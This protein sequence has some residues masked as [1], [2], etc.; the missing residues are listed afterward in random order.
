MIVTLTPN[1]SIDRTVT[2]SGFAVG[3]VNRATSVRQ[4]PGGKGVNV[5]RAVSAH[6]APSLAVMPLGGA[7]GQMMRQ[8]LAQADVPVDALTI[9][10]T[11]RI[12]LTLA[13]AAGVTTKVNEPG[14]A[15]RAA[16]VDDLLARCA[17]QVKEGTWVLGA[18]SLPPR[19]TDDFYVRLVE[20]VQ[21]AGGQVAVDSSGPAFLRALAA[22]PDLVKP[23][24]HELGEALGRPLATLGAIIDGA[25]ELVAGGISTV[26]VSLGGSGALAVTE[27]EVLHAKA[28]KV[29][30]VSTVGAGDALLAGYLLAL[31]RGADVRTALE[32]GIR[33]GTAA[34]T[35]PGSVMPGPHDIEKVS[36]TFSDELDLDVAVEE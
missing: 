16:E 2:L 13:D 21:A 28:A 4:D 5:S 8:L 11:T 17:R 22:G 33:F 32:N 29:R 9:E 36:V 6:G 34:V 20:T 14:P 26:V 1:P 19:S 15:L 23:N 35:L 3:S 10:D 30:P 24:H 18:G 25:Q 27:N 31:T 12:N 7:E